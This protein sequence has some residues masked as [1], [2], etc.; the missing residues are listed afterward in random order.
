LPS[1]RAASISC[2]VTALAGGAAEATRTKALEAATA[3]EPA[4][5]CRRENVG[6]FIAVS[7]PIDS[8]CCC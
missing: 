5:S 4:S 7:S 2:G 3:V 8:C 6:F 1:F